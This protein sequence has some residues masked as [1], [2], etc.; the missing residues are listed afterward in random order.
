MHLPSAVNMHIVIILQN[1]GLNLQNRGLNFACYPR[2][3]SSIVKS[4]SKE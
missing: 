1:Q 4:L 2:Q 3:S